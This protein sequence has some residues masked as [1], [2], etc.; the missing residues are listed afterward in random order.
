MLV[1]SFLYRLLPINGFLIHVIGF[2]FTLAVTALIEY[3]V[4]LTKVER[5]RITDLIVTRMR[6]NK[7][8]QNNN[9][10]GHGE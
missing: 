5:N 10:N 4:A 9:V 8:I 2:V 6:K 1:Y 3:H 7:S